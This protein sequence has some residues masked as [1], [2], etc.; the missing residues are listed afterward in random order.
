MEYIEE[1]QGY[2][3]QEFIESRVFIEGYAGD[4]SRLGWGFFWYGAYAWA[5]AQLSRSEYRKM[6]EEDERVAGEQRLKTYFF[7]SNWSIYPSG[8]R[9]DSS[10]QISC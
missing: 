8:R 9:G 2:T 3:L 5:S 7:G 1:E 10:T 4:G 6:R